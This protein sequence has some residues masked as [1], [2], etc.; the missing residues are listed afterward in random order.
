MRYKAFRTCIITLLCVGTSF[1]AKS[2]EPSAILF[3][4]L[5]HSS[6]IS[7]LE[8]AF[9]PDDAEFQKALPRGATTFGKISWECSVRIDGHLTKCKSKAEWPSGGLFAKAARPLLKRYVLGSGS[10][11]MALETRS[12]LLLTVALW[13]P[14]LPAPPGC[15]PTFCVS[16]PLPPPPARGQ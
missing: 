13:R 1:D 7:K 3:P 5:R 8:W 16:T 10:V 12:K 9:V 4:G 2:S 14:D 6:S 11:K 15:P